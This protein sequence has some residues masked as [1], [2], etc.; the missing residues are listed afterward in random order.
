MRGDDKTWYQVSIEVTGP[1]H[2]DVCLPAES[3]AEAGQLAI[4]MTTEHFPEELRDLKVRVC[5]VREMRR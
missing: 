4:A 3:A 5:L 1:V 2:D